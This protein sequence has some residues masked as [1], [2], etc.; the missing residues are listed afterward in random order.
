[1]NYRLVV[2]VEDSE[3]GSTYYTATVWAK[4]PAY[5]GGYEVTHMEKITAQQA[6]VM[7]ERE[8]SDDP[9]VDAAM[10]YALQALSNQSNSLFPFQ[11]HEL[12]SASKS[13]GSSNSKDD[14]IHHLKMKVSQ[15][16]M[17]PQIVEVDVVDSAHGHRLQSST[18]VG[19]G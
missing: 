10:S 8:V 2:H 11:L 15:G 16:N 18:F 3:L 9:D 17:A 5:G 19:Q 12:L 6:G 7:E 4:L 14:I 13:H 1:M